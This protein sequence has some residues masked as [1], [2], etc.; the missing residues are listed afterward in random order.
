MI[1]HFLENTQL[2]TYKC[3]NMDLY[4][5]MRRAQ[6]WINSTSIPLALLGKK[7]AMFFT[8]YHGEQE[9]YN[10]TYENDLLSDSGQI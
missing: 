1:C 9:T 10:L 5:T 7:E 6:T 2:F 4:I 8:Q 3:E